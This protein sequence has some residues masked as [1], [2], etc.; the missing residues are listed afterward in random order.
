MGYIIYMM[1]WEKL[2]FILQKNIKI[3]KKKIWLWLEIVIIFKDKT[4][5]LQGINN[6][7]KIHIYA[8]IINKIHVLYLDNYKHLLQK[9]TK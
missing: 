4:I 9:F 5:D 8:E 3:F 7:S 6:F 2:K 1:C